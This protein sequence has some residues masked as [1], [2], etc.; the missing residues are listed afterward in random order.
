MLI[1]NA[2]GF[3]KVKIENGEWRNRFFLKLSFFLNS[4]C[5]F[6]ALMLRVLRFSQFGG[7][8]SHKIAFVW[9]VY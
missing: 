8:P 9:T 2:R 4:F 7:A 5:Y 3:G 1:T 6:L